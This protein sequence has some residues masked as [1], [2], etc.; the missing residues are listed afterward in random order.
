LQWR[1]ERRQGALSHND[2]SPSFD[3][4]AS[5]VEKHYFPMIKHFSV[6]K[7][8]SSDD[9]TFFRRKTISSDD[10]TFCRRKTLCTDDKTL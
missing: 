3:V 5:A 2:I 8:I 1:E 7:T 6:K 4:F 10:K 9:K